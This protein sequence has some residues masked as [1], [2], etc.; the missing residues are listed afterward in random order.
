MI[1]EVIQDKSTSTKK[2][3]IIIAICALLAIA[4]AWFLTNRLTKN[5]LYHQ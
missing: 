4:G 1:T 3:R 2:T 5:A